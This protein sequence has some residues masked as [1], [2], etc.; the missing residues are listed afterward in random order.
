MNR[1]SWLR[2]LPVLWRLWDRRT[3]RDDK[4]I[5]SR[6]SIV[7]DCG[8]GLCASRLMHCRDLYVARGLRPPSVTAGLRPRSSVIV[9]PKPVVQARA[10]IG[11]KDGIAHGG[12]LLEAKLDQTPTSS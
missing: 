11:K 12:H 10:V 7:R 8:R 6:L 1:C 2:K 3:R 9:F 5:A 4:L